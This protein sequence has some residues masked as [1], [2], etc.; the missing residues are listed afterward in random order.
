[1]RRFLSTKKE[2]PLN[3]KLKSYSL[4]FI[5][6]SPLLPRLRPKENTHLDLEKPP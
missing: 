3:L 5:T 2:P 4:K 6:E 1:M